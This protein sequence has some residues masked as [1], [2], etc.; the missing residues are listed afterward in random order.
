MPTLVPS[1]PAA[2]CA[3]ALSL[4]LAAAAAAAVALARPARGIPAELRV[5]GS[6][7]RVLAEEKLRT[8]TTT[9]PTSRRAT[10]LGAGSGGSGRAA[11]IPGATALGLLGQAAR[12][13]RPLRPLLITD[14]F[15]F[16]L[17]LCGVGGSVG[18]ER[19]GLSWYLKVNHTDPEIGG[20]SVKL[21]AGDEVLWALAPFP[22]PDELALRA[23]HRV[24]A[25]RPFTV[26]VFS[27]AD[28]GRR[29]PAAGVR[30]TGASGPTGADGRARLTLERPRRLIARHGRDIPSNRVAVCVGRRCPRG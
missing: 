10:C 17:G 27:Y 16:G 26:R 6:G 19:T 8:A 12:S 2:A 20:D 14:H 22:Y 11:K 5:V 23:P 7:G 3:L 13:E 25:G 18:S 24:G 9:V 29:R 21:H 15:D 4:L 28:D 30:V 1:R